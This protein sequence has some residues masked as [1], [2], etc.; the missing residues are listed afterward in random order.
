MLLCFVCARCVWS[1]SNLSFQLCRWKKLWRFHLAERK[2]KLN[3]VRLGSWREKLS[4]HLW[5]RWSGTCRQR[6]H[7]EGRSPAYCNAVAWQHFLFHF[8]VWHNVN[9]SSCVWV[10]TPILPMMSMQTSKPMLD[11]PDVLPLAVFN[12]PSSVFRY[13]AGYSAFAWLCTCP[14]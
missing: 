5:P 3:L 8:I 2:K 1:L 6:F 13:E 12:R 14:S 10:V 9:D 7:V 4:C 11:L